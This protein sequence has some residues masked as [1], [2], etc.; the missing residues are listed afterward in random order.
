M[1]LT[2]E[3]NDVAGLSVVD[4][5]GNGFF[6]VRDGNI[7]TICLFHACNNVFDNRL[8][9]FKTRVVG[10]DDRKV[11]KISGHLSHLKPAL[12]GTVA[13]TAEHADQPSVLI[14]L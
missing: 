11:R 12:P 13:P 10:R 1:S 6:A 9:L 7:D 2:G 4:R 8:R 14:L 3:H 5:I